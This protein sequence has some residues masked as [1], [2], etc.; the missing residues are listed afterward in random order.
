VRYAEALL[1]A[2]RVTARLAA[3][4]V[5]SVGLSPRLRALLAQEG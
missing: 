5:E 1:P 3:D 2:S 4:A